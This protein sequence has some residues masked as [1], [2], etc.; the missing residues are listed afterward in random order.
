MTKASFM[1]ELE[2]LLS[3]ISTEERESA[4]QY[5]EDYF[6]DAGDEKEED[7]IAELGSPKKVA[8]IIQMEY[9][10]AMHSGDIDGIYTENGYKSTKYGEDKYEVL[11]AS[12]K[13]EENTDNSKKD[14][15]YNDSDNMYN[16]TKDHSYDNNY[17]SNYYY[18]S[19]REEPRREKSN[20]W[21]IIILA[22]LAI[23]VGIP[24][25]VTVFALAI[26]AVAVVF[27]LMIAFFALSIG[28]FGGGVVAVVAGIIT[29]F[30]LPMNGIFMGGVGLILLGLG[31]LFGIV[32]IT[33]VKTLLP[34][35]IRG[36]VNFL[37]KIV[38]RKKIIT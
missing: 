36:I 7:I 8:K 1:K 31:I 34:G 37:S 15:Y 29:L 11:N 6:A 10:S 35:F 30:T 14:S 5:Y 24:V 12:E 4:L 21:L 18:S 16:N 9:N 22:I 28:L 38:H 13:I 25:I 33:I 27:S 19:N 32:S 23:P 17:N 3:N 2:S 20:L 26:S